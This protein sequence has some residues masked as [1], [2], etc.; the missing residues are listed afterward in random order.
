MSVNKIMLERKV[1]LV[2]QCS[3]QSDGSMEH[4]ALISSQATP[5][6]SITSSG[7]LTNFQMVMMK[8]TDKDSLLHCQSSDEEIASK[9][10]MVPFMLDNFASTMIETELPI[11][12][13]LQ[14]YTSMPMNLVPR[15]LI[16]GRLENQV[17]NH[18]H[19]SSGIHE[20]EC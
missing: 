3:R 7:A 18:F 19:C 12:R 4:W 8:L 6:D 10:T 2:V 14:P 16:S 11:T 1:V 15:V 13:S 9:R 17:T 5:C 20:L